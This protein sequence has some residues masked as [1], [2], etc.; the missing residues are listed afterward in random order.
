MLSG[1]GTLIGALAVIYAAWVARDTFSAWKKQKIAEQRMVLAGKILHSAYD[2]KQALDGVRSPFM[3]SYEKDKA[4]EQLNEQG[5]TEAI[6]SHY[7]RQV[8]AQAYINRLQNT[9]AQQQALFENIPMAQALYGEELE[10][11]LDNLYHQFHLINV[12][13]QMYAEQQYESFDL[14]LKTN[15]S[16]SMFGGAAHGQDYRDNEMSRNIA[17]YIQTIKSICIQVLRLT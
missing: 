5:I 2:A 15:I 7:K 14:N 8:T 16:N 10:R 1:L 9:S 6:H 3:H 11:A 4:K 12:D 17:G 13:V